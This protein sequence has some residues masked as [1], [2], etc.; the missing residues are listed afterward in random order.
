MARKI[1]GSAE[2]DNV[3]EVYNKCRAL[4]ETARQVGYSP[5]TVVKILKRRGAY[6]PG[7]SGRPKDTGDSRRKL[8]K[9]GRRESLL[10]SG[11]SEKELEEVLSN[12]EKFSQNVV[13]NARVCLL[14]YLSGLKSMDKI[15]KASPNAISAVIPVLCNIISGDYN[16]HEVKEGKPIKREEIIVMLKA[17]IKRVRKLPKSKNF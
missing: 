8:A 6:V 15:E 5:Q 17:S 7:K 10:L 12:P 1:I 9:V 14:L 4:R 11:Y 2:E 3:V 13:E 16:L